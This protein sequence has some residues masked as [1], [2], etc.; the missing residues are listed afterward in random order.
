MRRENFAA[1]YDPFTGKSTITNPPL[2]EIHTET[3]WDATC[4]KYCGNIP[5]SFPLAMMH[6][7]DKTHTDLHGSLICAPFVCTPAFLNRECRNNDSNY[8][9]LGY[10]SNL[11]N[12]EKE[13][14]KGKLLP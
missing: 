2:D 3:I 10:I 9:V 1:N 11:G 5:N 7:Y 14:Q 8:M 4:R 6:F 12:I 13:R